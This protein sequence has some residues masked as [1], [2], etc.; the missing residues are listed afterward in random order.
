GLF[1]LRG[2]DGAKGGRTPFAFW[3]S[4]KRC[5]SGEYDQANQRCGDVIAKIEQPGESPERSSSS[6]VVVVCTYAARLPIQLSYA[7]HGNL[8][9][10]SQAI[11]ILDHSLLPAYPEC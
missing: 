6:L 8:A 1:L 3:P 7:F 2:G 4:V 5:L 9:F 10:F 11:D